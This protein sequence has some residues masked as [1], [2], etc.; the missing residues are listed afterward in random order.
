LIVSALAFI[1]F[2]CSPSPPERR[3]APV[4]MMMKAQQHREIPIATSLPPSSFG[5]T[6][7]VQ[8]TD[9]IGTAC[10]NGAVICRNKFSPKRET[11]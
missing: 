9:Q 3:A 2:V 10:R 5:A 8:W 6:G 4:M 7:V 11:E 1:S